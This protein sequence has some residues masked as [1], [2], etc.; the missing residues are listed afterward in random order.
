MQENRQSAAPFLSTL[1]LGDQPFEQ[2]LAD[3][4]TPIYPTPSAIS[5]LRVARLQH[6]GG[7]V[8]GAVAQLKPF[9][10]LAHAIGLRHGGA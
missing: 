2:K 6:D 10:R 4:N 3:G 8:Q 5:R 1:R 7:L 9:G